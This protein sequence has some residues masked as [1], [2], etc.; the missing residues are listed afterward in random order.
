MSTVSVRCS[1]RRPSPPTV[2]TRLLDE[3]PGALAVL[4]GH[5]GDHLAQDRLAHPAQLA[6]PLA[7]G[8]ADGRRARPGP[9]TLTRV[10]VDRRLDLH[11]AGHAEDGLLE[12]EAQDHLGVR[13]RH[14]PGPSAPPAAR[15]SAH[16]VEERVEQVAQAAGERVA[17]GPAAGTR[18]EDP[19]GP[20]PVVAGTALGV[21][22]DLVGQADLLEP[23]GTAVVVL[24]GVGME[25]A[26]LGPIGPLELL[27][28]GIAADTEDLVE[29]GV[30]HRPEAPRG[31]RPASLSRSPS[32]SP[33]T[34]AAARASG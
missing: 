12:G 10:A 20:V 9:G 30:G 8:T 4:A 27:V 16:P 33:T 31:H 21:L 6:R 1:L 26:G 32:R 29:V 34:R 24:V 14:R 15:G 13:S 28:G 22:Q 19:L 7:F 3:L 17:R 2:G 11:L 23:L 18:T 5:R 25:L